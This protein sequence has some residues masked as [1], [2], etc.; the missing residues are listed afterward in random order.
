MPVLVEDFGPLG[1]LT[2]ERSRSFSATPFNIVDEAPRPAV[3][4]AH[5]Y[6]TPVTFERSTGFLYPGTGKVAVLMLAAIG[7]EE[8]CLRTT[9]RA[10]AEAFSA[11]GV[12]A[13]RFDYPGVGDALD[14]LEEPADL[15]DWF[16]TIRAGARLL[17]RESGCERL[18]VVGQGLGGAFA[19][20]LARELGAVEATVL[21]A[22][23]AN[24]ARYLRELSV[25]ANVLTQSIGIERD[26][27][28]ATG[29]A[30]AGFA[31]PAG[32]IAAIKK[33]NLLSLTEHPCARALLVER[34]GHAG[35]EALAARLG[36]IGVEVSQTEYHGYGNLMTDPTQAT[37]P[38]E[39][40]AAIV[41]WV[42]ALPVASSRAKS[43]RVVPEPDQA[44]LAPPLRAEVFSEQP[45]RF[46][47]GGRMFGILCRPAGRDAG[48]A[49]IFIN[50]GRDY[51]IGW[52]GMIVGQ[53]R[54]IAADGVASLRFDA[55]GI[56][57]SHAAPDA[58]GEVLYSQ[59]QV[60]DVRAAIDQLE[61]MGFSR[62]TLIGRCSGAYAALHAAVADNRVERVVMINTERFV[63]DPDERVEDALRY[64]HRSIG[65]FGATLWK[66]DGFKRLLSGKLR[67]IP[68]G[69]YIA[70]RLWRQAATK[71]VP[72][73][74]GLTKQ[75]RMHRQVHGMMRGLA[76]RG[77]R[78]GLVFSEGDLGLGEFHTYFGQSGQ[79]LAVYPLMSLAMVP[80]ADHNFT[81]HGAR[82]RLLTALK[83]A[84]A[85]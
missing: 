29:C 73:L 24:G 26:P 82:R 38:Q 20:L 81:H 11:A 23:V 54:A 61:A 64:A 13:L 42:G 31:F 37:V 79:K 55:G 68:A 9:W 56:G 40:V 67:V 63:W 19:S 39:T 21:M 45:L 10:L 76:K 33:L 58:S 74:G 7:Y 4:P 15:A 17:R 65:D 32:R 57:D 84:L 53:A 16:E 49:A 77:T 60:A 59:D 70:Y 80:D 12:A 34:P 83:Q 48:T 62:I 25:W 8:M 43:R 69:R 78:I 27:D 41:D 85:L 3:I 1:P 50:A 35:D 51:H 2:A 22:P 71:L 52:A 72:V 75:G 66:R 44:A 6:G 47:P 30:V 36:E 14:P 5:N 18:V 46:G 28:D